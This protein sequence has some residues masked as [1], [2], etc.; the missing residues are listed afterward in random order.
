MSAGEV[1]GCAVLAW[2]CVG[3]LLTAWVV[4]DTWRGGSANIRARGGQLKPF[5]FLIAVAFMVVAAP[6][7]LAAATGR[8]F[9]AALRERRK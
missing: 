2:L 8:E 9:C 3:G 7:Y 4:P 1:I 5:A 6:M